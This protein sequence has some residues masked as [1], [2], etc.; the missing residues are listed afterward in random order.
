MPLRFIKDALLIR[1]AVLP[2]G[3]TTTYIADFDLGEGEKFETVELLVEIPALA[4]SELPNG[5]TITAKVFHGS[6]PSPTTELCNLGNVT[7]ATGTD[8]SAAR[9]FRFRFPPTVGRYV[10][11]GFTGTS[12]VAASGKAASVALVF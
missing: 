12:G 10:R 5:A 8:P 1:S 6:S 11:V 7:G 3:A 9:E 2:A 4:L